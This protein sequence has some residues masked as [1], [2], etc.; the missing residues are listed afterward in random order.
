MSAQYSSPRLRRTLL[1][2]ATLSALAVL[3]PFSQVS[4]EEGGDGKRIDNAR[5]EQQGIPAPAERQGRWPVP[6]GLS[7]DDL[8]AMRRATVP[9]TPVRLE[10]TLDEAG[11]HAHFESGQADLTPDRKSV[12]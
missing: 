9:Q 11:E 7:L 8:A 3:Y 6:S 5:I 2:G 4:A 10:R 12:V 1:C